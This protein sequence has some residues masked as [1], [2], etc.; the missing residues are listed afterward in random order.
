MLIPMSIANKNMKNKNSLTV[1]LVVAPRAPTDAVS[2]VLQKNGWMELK[3]PLPECATRLVTSSPDIVVVV[4]D[5]GTVEV[6]REVLSII[7]G[8]DDNLPCLI[9][10]KSKSLEEAVEV[11]KM[12]AFD[13]FSLPLDSE[14]F[15]HTMTN[16]T[17]LYALTKRVFL[18][19]NQMGW[20]GS[21]AGMIGVSNKMQEIFRMIQTVA[22][23]NTTILIQGESG[24]GKELVAK[25][26]H[27]MSPRA[28]KVFVDINCGAIPREL[29]ENEMF[30]HERGAYT[31]ADRRSV[32]SLERANGG[33]LFLDEISEMDPSLQVKLLRFLQER[34]FSRVGGNDPIQVDVRIVTATNRDLAQ[35][36]AKGRFREDLFFRLNVI[37]IQLPPLRDRREDIPYLAKHFLDKYTTRNEKIFVD[38]APDAMDALVNFDWPGN[39]RELENV[40]ERA[41]VLHQDSRVKV[42][43]LPEAFQ[44][45]SR[46]RG[47]SPSSPAISMDGG[48]ILPLDLVERYAVEFALK[49]CVGDVGEAADKLKVSQATLYRKLKQYGIKP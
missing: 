26:M 42:Q 13:F 46:G 34:T 38:F 41:V 11:M 40:I 35:E 25:A 1:L 19:E 44:E 32:G 48:R 24:T 31:G 16:A 4:S 23:T 8:Y 3:V 36:V 6:S 30:G 18:L 45:K 17:R 27:S 15:Q 9:V 12:G 21:F 2:A 39:V 49:H 33:S 37:P 10:A 20:P 22:K 29:L 7:K 14:R 28:N 47:R 5:K 43:H